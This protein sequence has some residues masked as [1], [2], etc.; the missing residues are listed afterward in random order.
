LYAAPVVTARLFM[1]YGPGQ[2]DER[3]LV[4]Y[5]VRSLLAGE[6]PRVSS[7]VRPV[8][9]VY[10]ADVVE[11]LLCCATAPGLEGRTID[12]GTGR[13]TTVRDVAL[14][15]SRLIGGGEPIFGVVEDRPFEQVRAADPAALT[16][17][18]G[19]PP[20]ALDAGLRDTVAWYRQTEHAAA[21]G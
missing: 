1:V 19:R 5:V 9:W 7:G 10:V 15:L 20:T 4:P 21:R 13:L 18:L 11:A 14:R 2:R 6:S 17:L 3:K 8:D 16:A 12:V